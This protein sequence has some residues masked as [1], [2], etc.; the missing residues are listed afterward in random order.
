MYKVLILD[1]EPLISKGLSEK[2]NWPGLKCE[3]CGI[4]SNGIEGKKMIDELNPD[5]VVSDIIM[6]G[7]TGLELAE[8]I[9]RNQEKTIIILLSGY[10]EF[11]Y[12]KE[13]LQHGVFDYLLK[14][15]DK[16]E[17]SNAIKKAVNKI[18]QHRDKEKNYENLETVLQESKPIIEQSIL[19]DITVKGNINTHH[20]RKMDNIKLTHGKGAVITIQL[21]DDLH[22]NLSFQPIIDSIEKQFLNKGIQVRMITHDLQLHILPSLS[23]TLP[24]KIVESRLKEVAERILYCLSNENRL[25]VSIGMGGLY[26]SV[27]ALHSSYL[28]SVEALSKSYFTGTGQLHNYDN[29]KLEQTNN[30]LSFKSTSFVEGYEEWEIEVLSNRF[31]DLFEIFK[32][33]CDKTLILSHS[34]ELLIKLS[35]VLSKWD[36]NFKLAVGYEQLEQFHTFDELQDFMYEICIEM[37]NHLY[38]TMN[39][40]NL[41]LVEQAKQII[42]QQYSNPDL[43]AQFIAEKLNVSVSY[44]SRTF[45]KETDENLSAFLTSRRINVA[46]MLFDNTDLKTNEVSKKVGFMDS[47]YFGQVFKKF[48]RTTPSAYKKIK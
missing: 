32:S 23:L 29:K 18:E 27:D 40:N 1:D 10:N 6:P 20:L 25:T 34:F 39:N 11:S 2:I 28:Q 46:K 5:I 24:N 31:N 48:T 36:K 45:K 44:L 43:N 13:A 30:Q 8:Y 33:T 19:Y 41:G 38:T 22:H 9:Q 17:V 12:A 37:K 15:T 7:H 3:I 14:P 26:A 16:D 4:A 21:Y 35:L 42:E 47:R